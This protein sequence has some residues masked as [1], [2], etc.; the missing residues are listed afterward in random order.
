MN[1]VQRF[2]MK[3]REV[4]LSAG[5]TQ[6]E[7]SRVL[8]VSRAYLGKIERGIADGLPSN[9][10]IE[11]MATALN[12]NPSVFGVVNDN[13]ITQNNQ[14]STQHLLTRASTPLGKNDTNNEYERMKVMTSRVSGASSALKYDVIYVL[15]KRGL[16]P[17][18]V[19]NLTLDDIVAADNSLM[20]K[21][22][23]L[24]LEESALLI[25]YLTANKTKIKERENV[26][27][28]GRTSSKLGL[29]DM[30]RSFGDY[31]GKKGE[32][33]ENVGWDR[34]FN[35]EAKNFNDIKRMLNDIKGH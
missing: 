17:E 22:V 10:S 6:E 20:V 9:K 3:L 23:K 34:S 29:N 4:R 12:V 8:C 16:S 33:L 31:L 35:T 19:V 18:N 7:L 21:K 25:K 32:T 11:I 14:T 30:V 5:V 13:V 26:V 24:E 27:F 2:G 15:A 1:E 28:Y